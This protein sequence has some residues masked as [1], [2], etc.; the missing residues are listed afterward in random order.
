[1]PSE[2]AAQDRRDR[3]ASTGTRPETLFK[4]V[5]TF[6]YRKAAS[7]PNLRWAFGRSV[8]LL[9]IALNLEMLRG[10]GLAL[11]VS[12]V[13]RGQRALR[14]AMMFSPV[15]VGFQFKFIFNDNVGLVNN[16]LQSLGL[17][18]TAIPWL[19]DGNLALFAIILAG[20][21]AIPQDPVEAAKVDGCT[22]WQSFGD[23]ILD[24]PR[25]AAG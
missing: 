10:L 17:S 15:L 14:N 18:D 12:K 6:N 11:M 13:T 2:T 25:P 20:L 1:M 4:C 3:H 23:V 24:K 19:V 8:V 5:G 9:S 22:P 21:Y 16:A 7:D